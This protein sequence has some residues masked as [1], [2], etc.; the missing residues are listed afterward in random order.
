MDIETHLSSLSLQSSPLELLQAKSSEVWSHLV[1][2]LLS[3][4]PGNAD[5]AVEASTS[6][7][8]VDSEEE[9]VIEMNG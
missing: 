8:V 4:L 1:H 9:D 3:F 2:S 7:I 6:K 5:L